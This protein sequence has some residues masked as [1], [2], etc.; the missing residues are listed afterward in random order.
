MMRALCVVSFR[1]SSS[2]GGASAFNGIEAIVIENPDVANSPARD[3]IVLREIPADRVTYLIDRR[4]LLRH[5][6]RQ[7]HLAGAAFARRRMHAAITIEQA[8]MTFRLVASAIA[9]QLREQ[10]RIFFG[11]FVCFLY[12]T[13]GELV[14]I[15]RQARL[16]CFRRVRIR[17]LRN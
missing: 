17:R 2:G 7:Q 1:R 12:R 10:R 14:R 16:R 15:E 13:S 9:M 8:L 4:A 11:V 3:S 5:P 6:L